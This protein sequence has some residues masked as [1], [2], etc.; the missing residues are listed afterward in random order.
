MPTNYR[1]P[2]R[3]RGKHHNRGNWM[4]LIRWR[5]IRRQ[6]SRDRRAEERRLI[7]HERYDSLPSRYPKNILW[8]YW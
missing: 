5:P 2:N 6:K 8:E 1:R 7:H 3:F 4:L